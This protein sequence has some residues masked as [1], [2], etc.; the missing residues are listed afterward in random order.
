MMQ[1][2]ISRELAVT[3]QYMW[4]HVMGKGLDSPPFRDLVK[5]ISIAE[6]KH[7]ES[8]AERLDHYGVAPTTKPVQIKVGGDLKQM[9]SDDVEAERGA[10]GLYKQVIKQADSEGD[11]VTRDLFE[12]I[13]A[14]EEDHEARFSS[15]LQ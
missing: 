1:E 3:T 14:A 4:H 7:A 15:L 11:I 12:G 9:I 13:L 10:I 5:K 6:M 2:S 8:I